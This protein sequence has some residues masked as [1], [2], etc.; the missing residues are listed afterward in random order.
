MSQEVIKEL[1]REVEDIREKLRIARLEHMNEI[2]SDFHPLPWK[3]QPAI[4]TMGNGQDAD[5]QVVD[6]NGTCVLST[7]DTP[8]IKILLNIIERIN[9]KNDK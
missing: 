7:G 9:P 3:F 5:H 1:E 2:D 8:S 4:M 6:A